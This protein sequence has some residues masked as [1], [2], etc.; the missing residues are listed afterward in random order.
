MLAN[1][2]LSIMCSLRRGVPQGTIFGAFFCFFFTLK[3]CQTA[4]HPANL[5]CLL[6]TPTSHVWVLT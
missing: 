6:M 3:T 4:Y 1:G 5:E 2:T